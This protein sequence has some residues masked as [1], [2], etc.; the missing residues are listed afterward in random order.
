V[1]TL[2]N[3]SFYRKLNPFL[4]LAVE[5]HELIRGETGREINGVIHE[6]NR[7][8]GGTTTLIKITNQKGEEIMGRP[9]G[10]YVT[11]ES[12]E[13]RHNN[14]E[15]HKNITKSFAAV[16]KDL[17]KGF[18]LTPDSNFLIVGLGNWNATP[19]SLGPKVVNKI[20]VTRHMFQFAPEELTGGLRPIAAIAPGVL[21]ITGIET[22]EIIKGII[23]KVKPHLIIAI[24][25]LAAGN[26]DRIASTI[27]LSDTGISPGSGI[28]NKRQGLNVESLGVP[29]IAI[30]V[31][32]I[33]NAVT[34]AFQLFNEL[35]T[36][37]ES[38]AASLP[39]E[40]LEKAIQLVFGSFG[41]TLSVTPK[42]IDELI[43]NAARVIASGLNQALHIAINPN[44]YAMYLQ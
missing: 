13:L 23:E 7:F 14:W 27:Q 8:P 33:V 15:A 2:T 41:T 3:H 44:D 21:G 1:I 36:R 38:L 37:N 29:V 22:A 9:L 16:L 43:S 25:A 6:Q 34:I 28:G 18:N 20:L 5:A 10:S 31:P 40:E 30:G 11:I 17:I 12:K 19:D 42:E 32:T 39:E 4:D 24:D 35:L 26:V